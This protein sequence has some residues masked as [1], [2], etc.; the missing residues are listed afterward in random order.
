MS[1]LAADCNFARC[2]QGSLSAG[3]NRSDRFTGRLNDRL[4]RADWPLV[5]KK[6]CASTHPQ[7]PWIVC[8]IDN[9][10]H[11]EE[12]MLTKIWAFTD[13]QHCW[14]MPNLGFLDQ[15]AA[16]EP[17]HAAS[18]TLPPNLSR[19]NCQLQRCPHMQACQA[20]W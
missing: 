19:P 13:L 16:I 18:Y 3:S 1:R 12:Q 7:H 15:M 11:R 8:V 9:T 20:G 10:Q 14:N 17:P 6:L 2:A 5:V 4:K